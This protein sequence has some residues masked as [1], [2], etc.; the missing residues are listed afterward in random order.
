MDKVS[1][2][3]HQGKAV[4][5]CDFRACKPADYAPIVAEATKVITANPPKSARVVSLFEEARFDP[6]I[7]LLMEAFV[8]KVTPH[9]AANGL[10]GITGLRKVAFLGIRPLYRCPAE[11]FDTVEAAKDWLAAR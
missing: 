1:I 5:I 3:T 2:V 10:V 4:I 7:V 6:S 8:R 11:L 9:M